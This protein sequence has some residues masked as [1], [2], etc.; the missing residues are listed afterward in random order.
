LRSRAGNI[1]T[2]R[3]PKIA[4]LAGELAG[5]RVVLDGE[6]VVFDDNGVANLALLQADTRRAELVA[7]DLLYLDGTSLIRKRYSDRRRVLEA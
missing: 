5:H 1:V 7:F 6:A 2:D 4:A 3:Y